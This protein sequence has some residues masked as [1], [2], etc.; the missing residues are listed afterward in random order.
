MAIEVKNYL[1]KEEVESLLTK[2]V[3]LEKYNDLLN[4]VEAL[5]AIVKPLEGLK[6]EKLLRYKNERALLKSTYYLY[7]YAPNSVLIS[8]NVEEN[9]WETEH[10]V[11]LGYVLVK[12]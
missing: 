8:E 1:T 2:F 4:R 7:R 5:E 11:D 10:D 6:P 9:G 3:S 12:E